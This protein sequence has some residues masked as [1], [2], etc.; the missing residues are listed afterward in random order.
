MLARYGT[1]RQYLPAFLGLAVPGRP[2]AAKLCCRR[3]RFCARSM[4]ARAAADDGRSAQLRAGG[5]AALPH[6]QD[7]KLDRAYL[8]N[9]ARLRGP[10]RLRAG[11]LFLAQSRDHVS[12]WNL[13]YDDRNWQRARSRP[14]GASICRPIGQSSCQDHRR[15][16]IRRARAAADAACPQPFATI[17]DGRLKLKK[18]DA[19][20]ISPA[21]HKLRAASAPACPR[22]RIE[23]LLQDVDEWC[24]FT[25]PSSR[26]AATSPCQGSAPSLL[27]TLIAHGTNLGLAAMSQSVDRV[28]AET[29]QDT[30]RWFLREA[31]LKAANTILVD[32]HHGLPF[33]RVWGDGA[34]PPPMASASRSSAKACWQRLSPLLRLLRSR[35]LRSTRTLPT[36]TASMRTQAIS[37]APREARYVLDGMLDND[38]V[39]VIREHTTDTTASPSTCSDCATCSG[40]P[41]CRG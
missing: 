13:V 38:T 11:S 31:T 15:D 3:S 20:P 6:R 39:L 27:A 41:S 4:P 12:F 1:L 25:P 19:L 9:L 26:S 30:S 7:G 40:S 18:R 8:G 17:H 22:V 23:D 33:S 37:C 5:L 29:L 32:H 2:P 34:G 21:L 10:R 16:S 14:T 36:S 35:A 24:G 28:T